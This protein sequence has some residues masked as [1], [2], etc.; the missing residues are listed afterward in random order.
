MCCITSARFLLWKSHIGQ[1]KSSLSDTV[2]GTGTAAVEFTGA[3]GSCIRMFMEGEVNEFCD[4]TIK[5]C[6]IFISVLIPEAVF[7]KRNRVLWTPVGRSCR[8]VEVI[9]VVPDAIITVGATFAL[10]DGD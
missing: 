2:G 8:S 3:E 6:L 4:R 5:G 9:G 7:G 10:V 1:A